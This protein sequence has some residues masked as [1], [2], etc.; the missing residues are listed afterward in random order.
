MKL[1]KILKN[2]MAIALVFATA[3]FTAGCSKE[4]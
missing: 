4:E 2:T 3:V 1:R